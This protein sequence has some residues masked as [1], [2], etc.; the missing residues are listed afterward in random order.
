MLFNN[1]L[2]LAGILKE[3]LLKILA[4]KLSGETLCKLVQIFP[5]KVL[6]YTRKISLL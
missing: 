3:A 4:K 5:P 1:L 2:E 6:V